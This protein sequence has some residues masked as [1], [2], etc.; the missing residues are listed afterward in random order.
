VRPS[1]PAV[2]VLDAH[3]RRVLVDRLAA[4]I[5]ADHPDGLV[6]VGVLDAAVMLVADLC[7]RLPAGPDVAVDFLGISRFAPDSGRVRVV[8]DLDV[9]I[10]DRPVVLVETIVDTGLTVDHLVRLLHLRRPARVAVCTLLDR[11][12]RRIL[13]VELRYRG[14]EV[15]DDFLVGYGLG[16]RGRY[17]NL[18]HIVATDARLLQHDPDV[19]L[20]EL[21][22]AAAEPLRGPSD[23]KGLQ[24][25][26]AR[27]TDREAGVVP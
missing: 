6:L 18:E 22:G 3:E 24:G 16:F 20:A 5:A 1:A 4:E 11:V 10:E 13:P 14:V 25:A 21:Y 23:A 19:H 26:G 27:V 17:A 9:V 2:T 15:D 12:R 8:R 7:R